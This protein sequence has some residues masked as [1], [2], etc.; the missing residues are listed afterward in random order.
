[1]EETENGKRVVIPKEIFA[2]TYDY[3]SVFVALSSGENRTIQ[4]MEPLK[5]DLVLELGKEET[6]VV[7]V[8]VFKDESANE[9]IE[10]RMIE[11]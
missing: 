2:P 1:M 9:I 7:A 10:E 11:F 4:A 5:E 3:I 8:Y 6:G